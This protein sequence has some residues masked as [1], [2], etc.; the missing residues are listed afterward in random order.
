VLTSLRRRA[1]STPHI[2]REVP[3]VDRCHDQHIP[4]NTLDRAEANAC[5]ETE[6]QQADSKDQFDNCSEPRLQ[7]AL[8]YTDGCRRLGNHS[9]LLLDL[10]KQALLFIG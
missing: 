9:Q 6:P 10:I 2:H 3:G 8:D 4:R 5:P 1:T 7:D